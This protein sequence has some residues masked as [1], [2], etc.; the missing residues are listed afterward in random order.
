MPYMP[1]GARVERL[2][3]HLATYTAKT[4]LWPLTDDPRAF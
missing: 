2:Y 3:R 1:L 4:R